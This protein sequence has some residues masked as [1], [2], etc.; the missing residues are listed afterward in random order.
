VSLYKE[1]LKLSL[2]IIHSENLVED[3]M[4]SICNLLDD[5]LDSYSWTGFYLADVDKR[6]LNLG[7]YTGEATD[8]TTIP[9]GKGI[10][11][12]A[13]ETEKTFVV[14]DV[15]AESNYIS[16]NINVKSEIVAPILKDGLLLG[17]IDIDSNTPAA[18]TEE[19][20][21]LLENICIALAPYII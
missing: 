19:D 11:G 17:Q 4:Q 16:C 13:A 20:Q 6:I 18:F 15:T 21:I 14:D 1:L 10:C 5:K 8:H 3:K 2:E 12:Q 9:F 7:P